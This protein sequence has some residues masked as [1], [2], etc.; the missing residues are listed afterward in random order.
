[1]KALVLG[2]CGFIGSHVV[3]ALLARGHSVTAYDR[4][5][6]RFREP[7][8]GVE[9]LFGDLSD[10]MAVA[11]AITGKEVVFHLVST[12]FPGTAN[13]DPHS[14]VTDNLLGTLSLLETMR[15]LG[16]FRIVYLSSG[17][18]VYGKPEVEVVPETH[19]LRPMNSYGIVKVAIESYLDMYG[20][21]HGLS[22]VAIRAANPFGPRQSHQ[23]VQGVVA[24]FM[25]LVAQGK[26][27]E[28]WG[29]GSVVRD[30]L[31]VSDLAELCV[32]AAESDVT[33]PL[34]AGSGIGR[35]VKEIIAAISK[36]S[37]QPVRVIHKASRAVD[38]PRSVLDVSRARELLGW[39]AA[40]PFESALQDTWNW[41]NTGTS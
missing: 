21:L 28:V 9:Y 39:E 35:S 34:N 12:T 26:P 2:G 13:L 17:G 40:T 38:V 11:E 14:D 1:M 18:T 24:T 6:E 10:K 7:L 23:G 32:R 37:D 8:A 3:D 25:R 19:P 29:D 15:S 22:P 30:Y 33:G 36:V 27:I 41:V 16:V 4:A 31:Y 5:A 20:A